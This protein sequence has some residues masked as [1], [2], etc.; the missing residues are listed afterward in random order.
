MKC[1]KK[2]DLNDLVSKNYY[3]KFFSQLDKFY[4]NVCLA[5]NIKL[6]MKKIKWI[7]LRVFDSFYKNCLF[8]NLHKNII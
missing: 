8:S 4:K 6:W 7:F 2:Q 5:K 3:F 1:I